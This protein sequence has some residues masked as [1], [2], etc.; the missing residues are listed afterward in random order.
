MKLKKNSYKLYSVIGLFVWLVVL[1]V[2][3]CLFFPSKPEVK[4]AAAAAAAVSQ[5]CFIFLSSHLLAFLI[6]RVLL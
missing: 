5:P 6:A 2:F 3:F 4:L 1:L